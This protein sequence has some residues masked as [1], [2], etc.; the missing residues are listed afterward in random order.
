MTRNDDR[1]TEED[2]AIY[3]QIRRREI[4]AYLLG[5]NS[6]IRR[7]PI[8]MRKSEAEHVLKSILT[9]VVSTFHLKVT[10]DMGINEPW[11]EYLDGAIDYL[12]EDKELSL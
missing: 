8:D 6:V 9:C 2:Q 1:W 10:D 4:I 5:V 7:T 12:A 11:L 3:E